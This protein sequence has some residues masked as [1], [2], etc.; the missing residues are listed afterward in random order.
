MKNRIVP[1]KIHVCLCTSNGCDRLEY[2]NKDGSKK[3][4]VEVSSRTLKSHRLQDWQAELRKKSSNTPAS[5]EQ[6]ETTGAGMEQC[7]KTSELVELI[8]SRLVLREQAAE[9]M[10]SSAALGA[11]QNVELD[12]ERGMEGCEEDKTDS[13]AT[14][15]DCGEL[16]YCGVVYNN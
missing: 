12:G 15:Y 16:L 9:A 1:T 10:G 4:G 13:S 7:Q 11:V 3:P 2:T 5:G 6:R 8:K 14:W